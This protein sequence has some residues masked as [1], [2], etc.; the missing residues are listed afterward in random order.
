MREQKEC[1]ELWLGVGQEP[2][3]TL[4]VWFSGQ[5]NTGAVVGS[6]GCRL[7]DQDE[8]DEAFFK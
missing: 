7:T 5:T 4:W 3:G 6:I 2:A 1:R 8:V